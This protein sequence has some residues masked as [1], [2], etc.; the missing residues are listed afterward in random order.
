MGVARKETRLQCTAI[1]REVG[2]LEGITL[3]SGDPEDWEKLKLRQQELQSMA[4][5]HAMKYVTAVYRRLYKVGNKAGK[6]LVWRERR[7][8][9]HVGT[10]GGKF[11]TC[12]EDVRR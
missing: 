2:K 10:K 12:P 8:R 5:M 1:E 9:E 3:A 4:E 6:L 7:T 11:R